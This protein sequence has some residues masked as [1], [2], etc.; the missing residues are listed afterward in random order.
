MMNTSKQSL[1]LLT[2]EIV[3][4]AIEVHKELGPGL[5]EAVYE[6]CLHYE[7]ESN[8]FKVQKQQTIPIK[9]KN[10]E[11]DAELRFDLLVE[12]KIIVELKAVQTLLPIF[13]AQLISYLKLMKKPKGLLLN[14]HTANLTN[15]GFKSFV[16]E[17]YSVLPEF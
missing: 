13:D 5:L 11:L 6:K 17:Y 14:F 10:L 8:G 12:D 15:E 4:L 9:Y 3:G 16:N 7:L 2:H 1:R